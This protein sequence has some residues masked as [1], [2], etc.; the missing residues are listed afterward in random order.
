MR[1]GEHVLR[2]RVR[3]AAAESQRLPLFWS[4]SAVVVRNRS[5]VAHTNAKPGTNHGIACVC[6]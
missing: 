5:L 2:V 6:E 4:D 1:V 3:T